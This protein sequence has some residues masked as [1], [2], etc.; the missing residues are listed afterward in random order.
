MSH[1]VLSRI[2]V[3]QKTSDLLPSSPI[4][5]FSF[6]IFDLFSARQ[7]CITSQNITFDDESRSSCEASLP[8]PPSSV[9]S[10]IVSGLNWLCRCLQLSS[11]YSAIFLAS[12]FSTPVSL[13]IVTKNEV[14]CPLSFCTQNIWVTFLRFRFIQSS[15]YRQV[16]SSLNML[17]DLFINRIFYWRRSIGRAF[18]LHNRSV[19]AH[20]RLFL[21]FSTRSGCPSYDSYLAALFFY[22][23]RV[24]LF[25]P[26]DVLFSKWA[27]SSKSAHAELDYLRAHYNF[28]CFLCIAYFTKRLQCTAGVLQ[29]YTVQHCVEK[30]CAS[31]KI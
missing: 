22:Y 11:I 12:V 15:I 21:L 14:Q 7:I 1:C 17:H 18:Y 3:N 13:Q 4:R 30:T 28:L 23:S 29:M 5:L 20:Y 26:Y 8:R 31:A 24:F 9:S 27:H 10:S 2:R 16:V 19:F 6:A 25:A